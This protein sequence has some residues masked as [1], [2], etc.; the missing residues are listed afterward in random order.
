MAAPLTFLID[1]D[2]EFD[3][4][5]HERLGEFMTKHVRKTLPAR[6]KD[7]E[8]VEFEGHRF[9]IKDDPKLA[10]VHYYKRRAFRVELV[11]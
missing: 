5:F 4:E 7:D 2:P 3:R 1:L 9:V 10:A 6:G 8:V 11:R